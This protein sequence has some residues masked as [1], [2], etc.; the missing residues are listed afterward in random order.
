MKY[1][2]IG[3]VK[4]PQTAA[5][6]SFAVLAKRGA[7][8]TYTS[9]VIAEE[10]AKVGVPF[11]VFDPIDVWWGLRLAADG[12]GKGLPVVVFGLEHADI[13]IDRD[14]GKRIAQAVVKENISCVISTFGM[15]KVAQRHLIA[16]FSEE[17]LKINNTP[18]HVFIEEAHEFVPQRVMGGLAKCFAAVEALV[19]MG[20]NRGIG[21][22]LINQRA[23]TLN[24][25][26]LTQVDTLLAFRNVAPQ[27]RKALKE[28][29]EAHSA[30]GDFNEFMA[31][32]PSLPTG[33]GWMWSPEFMEV[34][35]RIKI[36]KRETFH[37]DREKLGVDFKV[38]TISQT[39]IASFVDSFKQKNGG[40]AITASKPAIPAAS[41]K[42]Q[43]TKEIENLKKEL[44]KAQASAAH[45]KSYA[46][47]VTAMLKDLMGGIFDLG[48]KFK[49]PDEPKTPQY[50]IGVDPAYGKDKQATVIGERKPDGG[51]EI[52]SIEYHDVPERLG[53]CPGTIYAFLFKHQHRSF[54]KRQIGAATGY[55]PRSSGFE[56]AISKLNTMGLIQ[57]SGD[58]IKVASAAPEIAAQYDRD[59]SIT[60]WLGNLGKCP[61]AIYQFL[62]DNPE[63]AWSKEAVAQASGY[64]VF[65]SGFENGLSAL[66][67]TGLIKREGSMV[68]LNPELLELNH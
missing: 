21:V 11:V 8:K 4:V 15:P 58:D 28:W 19:V 59:F 51:V 57:K 66:N 24:K 49:I 2:N 54:S 23:A 9:A 60:S 22:T 7:G 61:R 3:S 38:P 47:E 33:E 68:R 31:S 5:T 12:K 13:L 53:K 46:Q 20:R 35:Q 44:A 67:A 55:S 39:D 26:V 40:A 6:K 17:L 50:V 63:Q 32:L 1:L 64:L 10:F 62:L 42:M 41:I 45:W 27:D 56:N 16:E 48:K 34:F 37:P 36:R 29:V 43:D 52:K 14:M 30:E 25:D 65:S 18:R